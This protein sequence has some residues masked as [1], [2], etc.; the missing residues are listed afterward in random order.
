MQTVASLACSQLT[1]EETIDFLDEA[2]RRLRERF[3]PAVTI[4]V[5]GDSGIWCR[6]VDTW[7][8]EQGVGFVMAMPMVAAVKLHILNT[9][10]FTDDTDDDDIEFAILPGKLL[11]M[12]DG[13]R[14]AVIR[15]RVDD[16][17]AP[18]QG[19]VVNGDNAWRYQAVITDRDWTAVDLWR[20]YNCRA[21][22]ERVFRIGKQAL[23]LG[24][25]VS[26]K[27]RANEA[28]FLLRCLA[29]NAD[30]RFQQHC[31]EQAREHARPVRHHGLEW[32]QP[33][34]YRS[35]GRLLLLNGQH[36]L[37]VQDNEVQRDLW[38]FYDPDGLTDEAAEVAAA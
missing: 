20:F 10:T 23:A 24:H 34:F 22:C 7:L 17:K 14:V 5:R 29:Y 9:A 36:V 12:G 26:R 33:R 25:L 28:A 31:E 19:K 1:A 32:R 35:P 18:P 15:R 16:P 38:A 8:R 30:L 27:Y 4:T 11:G 3:G 2:L 21:D 37:R 6:K 13:A